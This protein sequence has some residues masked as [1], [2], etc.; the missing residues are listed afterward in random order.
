MLAAEALGK[1]GDEQAVEP[2]IKALS[3]DGGRWR[4]RE[5]REA[6]AWALGE[7][8]DERAVEP[9]IGVHDNWMVHNGKE[10]LK[11]LDHEVE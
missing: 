5:V 2:L 7:I 11:K 4:D 10:V 9:L 8:G 6:A 1:I 3:Y